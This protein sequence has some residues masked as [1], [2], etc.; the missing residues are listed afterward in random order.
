MVIAIHHVSWER[1]DRHV[2]QF[3]EQGL[4]VL[5]VQVDRLLRHAAGA[6]HIVHAGRGVAVGEE[7]LLGGSQD[8]LPALHVGQG[9]RASGFSPVTRR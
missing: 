6:R 9:R 5:E 3:R 7:Q 2:D 8:P 1:S 4:L